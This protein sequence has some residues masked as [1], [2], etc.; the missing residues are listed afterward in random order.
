MVRITRP[1]KVERL[2]YRTFFN[3]DGSESYPSGY[4]CK[5]CM[6]EF[7][8]GKACIFIPRTKSNTKVGV[9]IHVE[10][11]KEFIDDLKSISDNELENVKKKAM[12]MNL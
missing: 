6:K 8:K 7:I 11:F 4:L 12:V 5:V 3:S 2:N 10:C 9:R 1:Y